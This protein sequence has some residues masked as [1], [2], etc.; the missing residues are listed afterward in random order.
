MLINATQQESTL[1][2][3]RKRYTVFSTELHLTEVMIYISM[4]VFDRYKK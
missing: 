4:S 2:Q 1:E 3:K